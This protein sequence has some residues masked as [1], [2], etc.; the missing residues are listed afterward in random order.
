MSLAQPAQQR[1]RHACLGALDTSAAQRAASSSACA[2][3]RVAFAR[4]VALFRLFAAS[5]VVTRGVF[6]RSRLVGNDATN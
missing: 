1:E 3:I 6:G 4:R 2:L 5:F